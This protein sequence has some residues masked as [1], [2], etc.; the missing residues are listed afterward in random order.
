M[1]IDK[2]CAE[3]VSDLGPLLTDG[4]VPMLL[5]CILG[6]PSSCVL[7][8]ISRGMNT[9][10]LHSKSMIDPNLGHSNRQVL[11]GR[12]P[13]FGFA[14][15]LSAFS[16]AI[17]IGWRTFVSIERI[18]AFRFS[19]CSFLASPFPQMP[20][21]GDHS[22]RWP[23]WPVR[24]MTLDFLCLFFCQISAQTLFWQCPQ[25]AI[26]RCQKPFMSVF[27][28]KPKK[29]FFSFVCSVMLRSR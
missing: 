10:L 18:L 20:G 5:K 13:T 8:C 26:F 16:F 17:A 1:V 7:R 15:I 27:V 29:A 2:L 4:F 11:R 24:R 12:M 23:Y 9:S 3:T 28:L 14:L 6:L 19:C 22:S 21:R 25:G